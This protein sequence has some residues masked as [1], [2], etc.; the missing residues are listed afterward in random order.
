M[1][2]WGTITRVAGTGA[3]GD[4]GDDGLATEATFQV[5]WGVAL[6]ADGGFLISD[7]GSSV[8]RKVSSTGTITRVAG[9]GI[10]GNS[11]DDGPATD[12]QLSQPVGVA[13]TADGGFL[14]ADVASSV[15]RKVSPTGTITRVAGTGTQGDSGDDGPATDAELTGPAGLAVTADGGFL[16]TDPGA[17]VVRAVSATG[18]ITRVAGTGTIGSSGDDGPALDAEFN[19]PIGIAVTA[20]GG[21]LVAD[22]TNQVVRKVSADGT[23]TRVAGTGTSGDSGD[24]GPATDAQLSTPGGLAVSADGGF[25]IADFANNVVRAVSASGII[26]R[27]AGTGTQGDSGDD[28]PATDAEL[29]SPVWPAVTADGSFVITDSGN[30]EVRR[31]AS[32]SRLR[33]HRSSSVKAAPIS[34][35]GWRPKGSGNRGTRPIFACARPGRPVPNPIASAPPSNDPC[36]IVVG[37]LRPK[38]K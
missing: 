8:V 7:P 29:A 17:H 35:W 9:T 31:V 11:G 23:I 36:S 27:V 2:A 19:G 28:G 3:A 25:L 15:V 26:T 10:A 22:A 1:S 18:T 6:T 37:C 32:A 16:I 5:P 12:A 20:D 30:H 34:F 4:S 14:I 24:D 33:S 38:P 13:V 21:F